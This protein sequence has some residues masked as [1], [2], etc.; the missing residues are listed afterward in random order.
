M[1]VTPFNDGFPNEPQ[2]AINFS[3]FLTAEEKNEWTQWLQ[4]AGPEQRDELVNILHQM[5]EQA[6]SAPAVE[7]PTLI[8]ANDQNSQNNFQ[9]NQNYPAQN[10]QNQNS[11]PQNP[12]QQN[13]S[14]N[15]QTPNNQYQNNGMAGDSSMMQNQPNQNYYP[16]S[17]QNQ[18]QFAN[19]NNQ[20]QPTA[21]LNRPK[22]MNSQNLNDRDYN[23]FGNGANINND[24]NNFSNQSAQNNGQFTQSFSQP[25]IQPIASQNNTSVQLDMQ[26]PNTNQSADSL[27]FSNQSRVENQESVYN[28][29]ASKPLEMEKPPVIVAPEPTYIAPIITAEPKTKE[30]QKPEFMPKSELPTQQSIA[31]EPVYSP[32]PLISDPKSLGEIQFKAN[33]NIPTKQAKA[34]AE[35]EEEKIGD[36]DFV[37]DNV[38]IENPTLDSID[39]NSE[40]AEPTKSVEPQQRKTV[41]IDFTSIRENANKQALVSIKNE[42]VQARQIQEQVHANFIDKTTEI[43]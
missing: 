6:K 21:N 26:K 27:N 23:N 5:W 19:Q 34:V 42:Y 16:A 8:N 3:Y 32:H 36:K 24:S 37:F 14:Q 43:L 29:F 33:L 15:R 1:S 22:G 41:G 39:N 30:I 28:P 13:N 38:E 7:N 20:Y 31:K 12:Q 11:F 9:Q 17:Q 4:S 2:Q 18:Q 35:E 40:I 10:Q 25:N